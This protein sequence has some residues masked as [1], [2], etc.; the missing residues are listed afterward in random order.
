MNH[1][2]SL[3]LLSLVTIMCYFSTNAMRKELIKYQEEDLLLNIAFNRTFTTWNPGHDPAHNEKL[4]IMKIKKL[5]LDPNYKFKNEI[6]DY[7]EDKGLG[8][9]HIAAKY[10]SKNLLKYLIENKANINLLDDN[11]NTPLHHA[12]INTLVYSD[13]DGKDMNNEA[14]IFIEMLIDAGAD[15]SIKNNM[16]ESPSEVDSILQLRPG[17]MQHNPL[18]PKSKIPKSSFKKLFQNIHNFLKQ[19]EREKLREKTE[20]EFKEKFLGLAKKAG[21]LRKK[22]ILRHTN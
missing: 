11:G 13:H 15:P 21:R 10:G 1:I 2:K 19:L 7:E 3:S 5:K 8:I 17:F 18:I 16:D 4:G 12:A 14:K 20:K 22:P 9:I 6:R